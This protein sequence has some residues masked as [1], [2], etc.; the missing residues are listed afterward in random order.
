MALFDVLINLMFDSKVA[1]CWQVVAPNTFTEFEKVAGPLTVMLLVFTSPDTLSVFDK[2]AG[3][4]IVVAFE[5][6]VAPRT[7][8]L[9]DSNDTPDTLSVFDNVETPLT[10]RLLDNAIGAKLVTFD[11]N[12]HR[13][14]NVVTPATA[15]FPKADT[16]PLNA[17][18][19]LT[20]V[21]KGLELY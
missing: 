18:L 21:K 7:E 8:R 15:K 6:I 10:N 17:A 3:P 16:L 20:N 14:L 12:M 19:L 5:S 11:P 9:E 4:Y 13:S 1:S 2:L